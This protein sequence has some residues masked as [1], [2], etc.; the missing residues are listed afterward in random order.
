MTLKVFLLIAIVQ[1]VLYLIVALFAFIKFKKRD[2]YVK[3]IGLLFL[4][5]ACS[6]TLAFVFVEFKIN[7]NYAAS[8]Y[9]IIALPIISLVYYLVTDKRVKSFFVLT[10]IICS[11]FGIINLL[12]IQKQMNNSY[13]TVLA[14]IIIL[15]YCLYY[16]YWLLKELPTTRLDRLPMFWIN[17]AFMIYYGGNLFILVFTDYLVNVLKDNLLV[18]W[19]LHNFLGIAEMMMIIFALW[20]DLKTIKLKSP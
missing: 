2:E 6:D 7:G 3:V 1:I 17:S 4:I 15:S 5:S 18:Y 12:V 10:T 16:F 13:T 9:L 8:A 20:I 11:L 14:T 19:S